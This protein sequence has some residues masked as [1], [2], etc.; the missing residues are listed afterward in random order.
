MGAGAQRAIQGDCRAHPP[1]LRSTP[2]GVD[3]TFVV[4]CEQQ[5]WRQASHPHA[6]FSEVLLSAHRH[7]YN[8]STMVGV[9]AF[10]RRH[11]NTE[12]TFEQDRVTSYQ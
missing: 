3:Y 4:A 12:G 7:T 6:K 8:M 5:E 9:D 1:Q 10:E 2:H 11:R